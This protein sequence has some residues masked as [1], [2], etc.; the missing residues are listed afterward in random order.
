MLEIKEKKINTYIKGLDEFLII[1]IKNVSRITR[2]AAREKEN[3]VAA[4]NIFT[5]F[6]LKS[7]LLEIIKNVVSIPKYPGSKKILENLGIIEKNE[8][9]S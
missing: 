5:L 7:N 1:K 6:F 4:K 2:N 3:N 8:V 9:S